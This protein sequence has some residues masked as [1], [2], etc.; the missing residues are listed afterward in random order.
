MTDTESSNEM[1]F[2]KLLTLSKSSYIGVNIATLS[3]MIEQIGND[4]QKEFLRDVI[5]PTLNQQ[6]TNPEQRRN[7]C[8]KP[9]VIQMVIEKGKS[10]SN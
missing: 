6:F 3:N 8:F 2:E 4:Q 5:I 1:T 7:Y 10:S 9:L